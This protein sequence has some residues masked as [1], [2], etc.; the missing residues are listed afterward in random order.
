MQRKK[1]QACLVF[2]MVPTCRF[3]GIY[4]EVPRNQRKFILPKCRLPLGLMSSQALV[5]KRQI[6]GTIA[7]SI[8]FR[9]PHHRDEHRP[10]PQGMNEGAPRPTMGR[11]RGLHAGVLRR[12]RPRNETTPE[13]TQ[14]THG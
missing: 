5:L 2:I 6:A 9:C 8:L 1:T 7:F 4:T 10:S 13:G 12:L 14:P 3:R 11:V